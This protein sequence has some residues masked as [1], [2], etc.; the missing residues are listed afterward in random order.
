M[1]TSTLPQR[2]TKILHIPF[3]YMEYFLFMLI[4]SRANPP[5]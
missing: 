1:P 5:N 4:T 3:M 2:L